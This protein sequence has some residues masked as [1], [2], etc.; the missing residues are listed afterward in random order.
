[1][2][3]ADL[4]PDLQRFIARHIDSVEKLEI[5]LLFF[6]EPLRIWPPSDVFHQIQSNAASVNQKIDQLFADGFLYKETDGGFRFQPKSAAMQAQ[7]AALDETYRYRRIKLIEAIFSQTT[8]ELRAFS[9][10]FKL[11]K[12]NE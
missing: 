8:E 12:E 5:L 4:S 9:N 11:R 2:A 3:D 10:A 7:V 6:R 1:M